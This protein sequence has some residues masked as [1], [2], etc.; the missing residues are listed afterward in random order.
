MAKIPRVFQKIFALTSGANQLAKFGSL[1][2]GAPV[3]TGTDAA[4]GQSLAQ[5]DGGWFTAILGGNSPAI[6]DRNTL[7]YI[8]THQLAYLMQAG[9]AEW[10][11]TTVYYKGSLV[12]SAGNIY[13]SLTDANSNNV[14]TSAANWKMIGGGYAAKTTTYTALIT[15]DVISAYAFSGGF[16]VTLPGAAAAIGKRLTIKKTDS[17]ANVVT[18][19]SADTIDG[20]ASQTLTALNESMTVYSNGSVWLVI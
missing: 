2:A 1:A 6:E 16:T 20:A 12:N 10:E 14:V 9:V 18:V 17:S 4:A 11:P 15:D 19:A 3:F 13:I 7:D 8:I 5:F